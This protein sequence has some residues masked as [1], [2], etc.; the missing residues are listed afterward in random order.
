MITI[1]LSTIIIFWLVQA[2]IIAD[3][4]WAIII[5]LVIVFIFVDIDI[6]KETIEIKTETEIKQSINDAKDVAIIGVEKINEI[7]TGIK[8]S[9]EKKRKEGKK[10][11]FNKVDLEAADSFPK[12]AYIDLVQ[13]SN[14]FAVLY[15]KNKNV[16]AC[17]SNDMSNCFHNIIMRTHI[18]GTRY[19]CKAEEMC[20]KVK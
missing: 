10:S 14:D 4:T 5:T 15:I 13:R 11:D 12:P 20:Y 17:I 9:V 18:D 6:Q 16:L 2:I 8:Q 1:I 19:I 3:P 7:S